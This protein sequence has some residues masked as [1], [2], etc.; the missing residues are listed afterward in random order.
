MALS[1]DQLVRNIGVLLGT[2]VLFLCL[3]YTALRYKSR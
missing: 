1:S 3:G 2:L